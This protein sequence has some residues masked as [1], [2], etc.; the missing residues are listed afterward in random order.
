MSPALLDPVG[1]LLRRYPEEFRDLVHEQL[2]VHALT[3]RQLFPLKKAAAHREL[4]ASL[5]WALEHTDPRG[6][7][8]DDA[9]AR[10]RRLGLAHR[11]L[12][13]PVDLYERF[14][15]MCCHAIRE[16]NSRQRQPLPETL[17]N[18]SDT[19]VAAVCR[20]MAASSHTADMSGT[21]PAHMA[22][23]THVE[24][25]SSRTTAVR[26][27]THPG[28]EYRPGQALMVTASYLPG[29]WRPLMPALPA[30]PGGHLEFH[31]R[32]V[33][34]GEASGLLARPKV[35]DYWTVGGPRGRIK[36]ADDT[37]RLVILAYETGLAAAQA[38]VFSLL[39]QPERPATE[40]VVHTRYPGDQ[41]NLDLLR[42]LAEHADWLQVT[43]T[44]AED[45]DPW[46]LPVA[47]R[48]PATAPGIGARVTDP[49]DLALGGLA[50]GE[51]G[52]FE[53]LGV[54]LT[55]P[56]DDVGDAYDRLTSAAVPEDRIDTLDFDSRHSWP[57]PRPRHDHPA[58]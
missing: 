26:L 17:M 37:T 48:T 24:R 21:P 9:L 56:A 40:L 1:A 54:L 28:P 53:G 36:L 22:Q 32:A 46:W 30:N 19:A 27:K 13:F 25:I 11:R 34:G 45:T 33:D 31:I 5:A 18:T 39:D 43:V 41:H 14:A 8:D 6:R 29:L 35:G 16:L 57:C 49:V 58:R 52:D 50:G 42:R 7:I 38:Y 12:G 4:A 3:A 47:G 51:H 10:I 15:E 20:A 23:V 2:F 44:V 55:G